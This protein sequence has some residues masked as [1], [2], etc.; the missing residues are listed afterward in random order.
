VANGIGLRGISER[1][2][3]LQ[4]TMT[5]RTAHGQGTLLAIQLPLPTGA[6]RLLAEW[7]AETEYI[8]AFSIEFSSKLSR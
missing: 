7:P 1:V 2:R 5:I 8:P 6:P 4:G 3:E